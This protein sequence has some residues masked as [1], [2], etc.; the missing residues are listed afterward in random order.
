MGFMDDPHWYRDAI[1]YEVHVKAFFDTNND[2]MGDFAGLIAKLDYLEELGVNTLW[3]LPFYPSPQRDDGYDIADYHNVHSDYGSRDDV[4]KLIRELHKREMRLITELV[5]NHTSDQHPWFQAA[6]RAPAG[7]AKRDFYVWSDS[8]LKYP[9][10]RVIFTD[11]EDSNWTW[12]EEAQAYYWHRFFSHQPDLNFDNPQVVKVILR[13][14]RFWLDMGVDGLRLDAIPY[15]VER[16]G[17]NCENLAETHAVI[18]QMRAVVDQHY[19]GRMFLAEANQW[20]EDVREYFGEGDECHMAYHFPLMPRM[21]MALAQEDRF[22]ITDILNQTPA[23]PDNC[24]WAL[25]LRNHDELTLEMVTDRERD[26]MYRA[27]ASDPRM[28]VNVGI[29]RRLAPLLENDL[30]KI[31]LLNFLLMT[32]PGTPIVYYG[33]EIGMGDNFYLG[34][35]NGVRTPMQWSPDRNA[36][37]SRADPQRLFLPPIMD[38]VYGYQAINVEA[39]NRNPSSLLNWMR[40]LIAVR[41][42]HP[43]F[44]R[45]QLKLLAP[46]NRKVFAYLR[47]ARSGDPAGEPPQTILCVANLS[48]SPQPVELDLREYAGL[49]PVELMSHNAFPP[50]GELPYLLTLPRYG[51]YWFELS[52]DAPPPTWHENLPPL[53]SVPMLVLTEPHGF[54][55][56]KAPDLPGYA[57]LIANEVKRRLEEE[58]LPQY[59]D[60]QRWFAGKAASATQASFQPL[61]AWEAPHGRWLFAFCQVATA[62]GESQTYSL[63]LTLRWVEPETLAPEHLP[64]VLGRVRRKAT[65]GLLLEAQADENFCRDLVNAIGERRKLSLAEGQLNFTPSQGYHDWVTQA[66]DWPVAYPA[67]EQS[68]TT[69]MLGEKLVLKLFRKVTV[70]INPE[71]EMGRHLTERASF[72]H[73]APM[74]GAVEW[75]PASAPED[76]SL[77]A[78][79][80]GYVENQGNAWDYSLSYLARYLET[81]QSVVNDNR[82]EDSTNTHAPFLAQMQLLGRRSGELHLALSM[83]S[84]DEAFGQDP[85]APDEVDQWVT[86]C[87]ADLVSSLDLLANVREHLPE[88]TRLQAETVLARR[89]QLEALAGHLRPS[90]LQAVKIRY[91]GDYHLG[92]VLVTG[93]DFV[94]IDFEGEPA[95]SLDERRRKGCPLRDVAGML[96][97][98]DYAAASAL[99]RAHCDSPAARTAVEQLLGGWRREVKAAFLA[100]YREGIKGCAAYPRLQRHADLL[101]RLFS[102]EKTLYE[103]RYELANRPLWLPIPLAGLIELLEETQ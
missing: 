16:E 88:A 91:H 46:G 24:Q 67:L 27:Y 68:N 99:G 32:L 101:I 58:L 102:L 82:G 79:L 80:Q 71:W 7:S 41:R 84:I 66:E 2:G 74:L 73:I 11:S 55:Q 34:D 8:K 44:G 36:G 78:I 10:T 85:L 42:G 100:G 81:W 13:A 95:R 38:P 83:P 9:G 14:M 59:L 50:V 35:R 40:R 60:R 47:V 75:L 39:Q 76:T 4:R 62:G 45:G 37:F 3:L 1:I 57:E 72:A 70:G 92:Q 18:K 48:H 65:P 56:R 86:Q 87:Q 15:L 23:I 98:F 52:R 20:P 90:G 17:T 30:D 51:Y 61:G 22:P 5:I 77:L 26:T 93:N 103:L 31:K 69:V 29:C 97:S 33:D 25:F 49:V 53:E 96:R 63:P 21:Y 43:A 12:D 54:F 94:I 89:A 64:R 19:Q 6:R 28:R